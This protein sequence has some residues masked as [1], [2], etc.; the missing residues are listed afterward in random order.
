MAAGVLTFEQEHVRLQ[1]VDVTTYIP[2]CVPCFF[3]QLEDGCLQTVLVLE[4]S[5]DLLQDSR[6]LTP[7][8]TKLCQREVGNVLIIGNSHEYE[9]PAHKC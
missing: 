2:K 4:Q 6:V 8:S 3:L 1:T 5:D 7:Q 9:D